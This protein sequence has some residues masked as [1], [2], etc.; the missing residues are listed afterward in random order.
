MTNFSDFASKVPQKRPHISARRQNFQ[1]LNVLFQLCVWNG[2][3]A[4]KMTPPLKNR[5][6]PPP[7]LKNHPELDKN[8]LSC[9]LYGALRVLGGDGIS[10]CRVVAQTQN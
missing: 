1:N 4:G 3:S 9:F 7:R 10:P 6:A 5:D 8:G 2:E